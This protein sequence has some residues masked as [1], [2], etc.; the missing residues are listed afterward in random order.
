MKY[1]YSPA[2]TRG[3]IEFRSRS[4]NVKTRGSPGDGNTW[5]ARKTADR[6]A[7]KR[8]GRL[9]LNMTDEGRRARRATCAPLSLFT[10]APSR[11]RENYDGESFAAGA[12]GTQDVLISKLVG[13]IL[14][15]TFIFASITMRWKSL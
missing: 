4:F 3:E 14:D 2:R 6:T 1:V 10:R 12:S 15:D 7:D 11:P 9:T 13:I 8:D 5:P